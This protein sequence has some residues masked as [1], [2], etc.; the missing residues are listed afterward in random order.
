MTSKTAESRLLQHKPSTDKV[1][2]VHREALSGRKYR[3][4]FVQD[5]SQHLKVISTVFI[6]KFAGSQLHLTHYT[7]TRSTMNCN[8]G[9][10]TV[11]LTFNSAA[12]I[13][14]H[15]LWQT[16]TIFHQQ[17]H[18]QILVQLICTFA[19]CRRVLVYSNQCKGFRKWYRE[20]DWNWIKH[21]LWWCINLVKQ[22]RLTIV[23]G[24]PSGFTSRSV[25]AR[26]QVSVCSGYNLCHPG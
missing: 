9:H 15:T 24:V 17:L 21:C 19:S 8:V 25:H 4:I 3:R 10:V 6:R 12:Q 22:V 14:V 18:Q 26:L 5:L 16:A 13:T 23:F 2:E 11:T 1:A 20:T 7:Y